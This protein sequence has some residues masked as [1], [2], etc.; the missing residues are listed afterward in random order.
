[1]ILEI[2]GGAD[3]AKFSLNT[4]TNNLHFTDP[5]GQDFENPIS[6]DGDNDYEVQVR[7][8]GT[9]YHPRYTYT[10]TTKM[11]LLRFLLLV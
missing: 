4:A 7:I 11:M 10:I 8:V 1:M 5:N 3:Q 2:S 9:N 6:A